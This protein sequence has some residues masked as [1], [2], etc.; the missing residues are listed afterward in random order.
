MEETL[1]QPDPRPNEEWADFLLKELIPECAKRGWMVEFESV[2]DGSC[3]IFAHPGS[4]EGV[5]P[6]EKLQQLRLIPDDILP[7]TDVERYYQ[8]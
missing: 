7:E 2:E 3:S 5:A 4:V 1:K 8:E 6:G